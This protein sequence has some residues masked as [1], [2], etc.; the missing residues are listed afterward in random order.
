[1]MQSST[2]AMLINDSTVAESLVQA[3]ELVS[4]LE[5]GDI[6]QADII[7]NEICKTREND[8][9][10]EIGK[11]TRD[12]HETINEFAG[13]SRLNDITNKEMTDA[14]QDLNH[15]IG[16]TEQAANQTLTAVEHSMPLLDMLSERAVYLKELLQT[17]VNGSEEDNE[18]GF[19]VAEL[20]AYFDMVV[21]EMKTINKDMNTVLMA[22]SYQ[23]I[24]GQIIQRVSKMVHDVEK[25]LIGILQINSHHI[26]DDDQIDAAKNNAGHGPAVPGV[27]DGDVMNNQD[28]VDDL[29]STLGF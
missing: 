2:N 18:P 17:Q 21:V 25:S 23:D 22:Q 7:I 29:L 6:K 26:R 16:L 4:Q 8:L 3:K 9:F 19:I 1:M 5:L 20:D 13:D 15:V 24:T 27:N 14:R 28:D 12:L 10:Q 11:L